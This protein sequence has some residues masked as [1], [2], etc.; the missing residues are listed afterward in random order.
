MPWRK[1]GANVLNSHSEPLFLDRRIPGCSEF[2]REPLAVGPL[3][4]KPA[5]PSEP[6]NSS[7]LGKTLI[8]VGL[9]VKQRRSSQVVFALNS[10]HQE[11]SSCPDK[12]AMAS[13][14]PP[15]SADEETEVLWLRPEAPALGV[16]PSLH[17]LFFVP[18]VGREHR[19]Q[20]SVCLSE[21]ALT[22]SRRINVSRGKDARGIRSASAACGRGRHRRPAQWKH[23]PPWTL[24]TVVNGSIPHQPQ[25]LSFILSFLAFN[26]Y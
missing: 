20:I 24:N 17:I 9:E 13:T 25:R 7:E 11:A 21:V 22:A 5:P 14:L 15:V 2:Q 3:R 26:S 4:S 23:T 1:K 8:L 19:E 16:F 10:S 18:P 12:G 6:L